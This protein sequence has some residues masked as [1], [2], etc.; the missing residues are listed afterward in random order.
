MS[1]LFGGNGLLRRR[2]KL[3][4]VGDPGPSNFLHDQRHVML[5]FVLIVSR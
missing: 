4:S 3:P 1:C 5:T 2:L